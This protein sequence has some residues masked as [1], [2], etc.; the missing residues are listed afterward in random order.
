MLGFLLLIAMVTNL[1]ISQYINYLIFCFIKGIPVIVQPSEETTGIEGQVAAGSK[2]KLL[3]LENKKP[4]WDD[5]HGGHVLN[6]QVS[7]Q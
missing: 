2:E 4:K 3:Y 1:I 5:A 6:F 7:S